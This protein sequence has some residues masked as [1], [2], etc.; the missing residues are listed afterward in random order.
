M[1]IVLVDPRNP[2]VRIELT[3]AF[4]EYDADVLLRT[5]PDLRKSKDPDQAPLFDL[6]TEEAS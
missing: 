3:G 2:S 4:A 6:A 5:F 1:T